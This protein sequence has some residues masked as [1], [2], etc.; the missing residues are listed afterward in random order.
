MWKYT[1]IK[2]EVGIKS[3]DRNW[4]NF[5][6]TLITK[7]GIFIWTRNLF[8]P[9]FY[10]SVVQVLILSIEN[11][12]DNL[13]H[14]TFHNLTSLSL[15]VEMSKNYRWNMLVNFLHSAPNLKDLAI[16]VCIICIF[17]RIY[18]RF[19]P[20]LSTFFQFNS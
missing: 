11:N 5:L 13:N 9:C 6:Q 2:L 4:W 10:N 15:F 1:S 16:K 19:S 7:F 17:I 18:I 8:N 20:Q 12:L 14:V 3:F